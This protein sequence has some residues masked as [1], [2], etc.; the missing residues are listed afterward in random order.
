MFLS[1]NEIFVFQRFY[2]NIKTGVFVRTFRFFCFLFCFVLIFAQSILLPFPKG[3][4]DPGLINLYFCLWIVPHGQGKLLHVITEQEIYFLYGWS[5]KRFQNKMV[6][7]FVSLK[8]S[9][10]FCLLN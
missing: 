10:K 1:G 7:F 3:E 5:Q 4:S 2:F 6:Y 8:Y 9:V